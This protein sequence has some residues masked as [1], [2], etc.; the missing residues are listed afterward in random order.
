MAISSAICLIHH[1]S[2]NYFIVLKDFESH[3]LRNYCKFR[4]LSKEERYGHFGKR[5]MVGYN[6]E[7]IEGRIL[8]FL[9]NVCRIFFYYNILRIF[10]PRD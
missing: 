6:C 10:S 2:L 9:L 4:L 5:D 1:H 7:D 8:I 3:F